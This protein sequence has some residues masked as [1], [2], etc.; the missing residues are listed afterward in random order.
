MKQPAGTA[1]GAVAEEARPV[2]GVEGDGPVRGEPGR[3]AEW[4]GALRRT[5]G[6][7]WRDDV[8]DFA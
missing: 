2:E 3:A 1:G 4:W 5:P 6:A 7:F 8:S